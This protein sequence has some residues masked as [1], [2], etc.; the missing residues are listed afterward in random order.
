M[1]FDASFATLAAALLLDAAIGYPDALYR[2]IGHPVTWIGR[3]I[4]ALDAALNRD[5][6][7]PGLRKC[8]G[9]LALVL[10]VGVPA[11]AAW[12]LQTTLLQ[13]SIGPI[14][15]AVLASSLLAA[16]SLYRHVADV[17]EALE[18]DGI[19]EG[20]QAVSRIVG[21]DVS[22]LDNAG[23]ARAAIESL[24]E[25]ASDG[26]VA[27]AFWFAVLGLPGLVAYKAINTADSMIGHL[28]ARYREF[29]WAAARLDDV[30][31]LPAS[32]LTAVLFAAAAVLVRPASARAALRAVARDA[33]RHRSPNAGWPE[34]A[35][36]GA[37]GIKL[38]GPRVY[39][40][41][42]VDDVWMGDG[43]ETVTAHDIR[44]ALRLALTAWMLLLG[45]VA[46]IAV[47]HWLIR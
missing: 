16:R 31:N 6:W 43:R 15:V 30:V 10:I 12:A 47:A 1:P 8:A 7:A 41:R 25:N 42:R 45:V 39:A 24:A 22:A 5:A 44:R 28:N 14:I 18:Q 38:A 9:V 27:P 46:A 4:A 17:A 29:G 21:R 40:G 26:L 11:G 35:M 3:L 37:L 19:A 32:R 13:V 34:S 36:A 23:V 20:R 2:T 33:S